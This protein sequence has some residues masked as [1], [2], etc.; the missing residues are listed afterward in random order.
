ML[1]IS[2]T[3]TLPAPRPPALGVSGVD[4]PAQRRAGC[5]VSGQPR[6]GS[7]S[8]PAELESEFSEWPVQLKT[9]VGFVLNTTFYFFVLVP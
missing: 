3:S 9:V 5:G 8:R 6:G 1:V 2:V 4:L 7:C